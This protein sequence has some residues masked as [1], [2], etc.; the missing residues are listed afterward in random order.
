M[1]RWKIKELMLQF[2]LEPTIGGVFVEGIQDKNV[3]SWYLD[4]I[5][6]HHVSVYTI[7]FVDVPEKLVTD[8]GLTDNHRGRVQTLAKRLDDLCS[9]P[10]P[11]LRCV[12]DSDY[13]FIFGTQFCSEHL[14]Y[15]DYT[16]LDMYALDDQI[17]SKMLAVNLG[18]LGAA[19]DHLM[20]SMIEVLIQC[21]VFRACKELLCRDMSMPSFVRDWK[22][23]GS[24]VAFDLDSFVEKILTSNGL[25]GL[26][27]EFS[28]MA[29]D[30]NAKEVDEPRKKIHG[31]DYMELLGWILSKRGNWR[32]YARGKK[33]VF[34]ML[35]MALDVDSLNG[36]MLFSTL[37]EVF[38]NTVE[39]D[40]PRWSSG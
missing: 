18:V 13:D 39:A 2:K 23:D 31:E 10:L 1:P 16:S 36:E 11:N 19:R 28:K 34:A 40:A 8:L 14:L 32:G 6:C 20:L 38:G 33:S 30:L 29:T 5:G 12:S 22:L 37:C 4:E 17:V 7:E 9:Q 15:T 24:T 35:K 27:P 26:I 21:F 3:Y 25:A